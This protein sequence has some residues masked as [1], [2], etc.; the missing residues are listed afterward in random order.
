MFLVHLLGTLQHSKRVI[1]S[2]IFLIQQSRN[3]VGGSQLK[4]QTNWMLMELNKKFTLIEERHLNMMYLE[5]NTHKDTMASNLHLHHLVLNWQL[6]KPHCSLK[7]H[8][9]SVHGLYTRD[10][11]AY[12]NRDQCLPTH[13]R[14]C[15]LLVWKNA[16]YN[17]SSSSRYRLSENE[18]T[19]RWL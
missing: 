5:N 3:H 9:W 6:N 4:F 15:N 11:R 19:T 2:S 8:S 18:N 10:I 12:T 13:G 14:R 17:I 1:F 7:Y 16:S